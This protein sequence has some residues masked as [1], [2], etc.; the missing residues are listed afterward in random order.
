MLQTSST[1]ELVIVSINCDVHRTATMSSSTACIN[2]LTLLRL[3]PALRLATSCLSRPFSVLNRPPPKYEGHVPLNALERSALAAG[4]AVMSLFNPRR[5]GTLVL[6]ITSTRT[7]KPCLT[8]SHR[9]HRRAR[10]NHLNAILHL[11]SS[12]RHAVLSYRPAHPPRPPTHNLPNHFP[13]PPTHAP[14]RQRRPRLC[15][16]ARP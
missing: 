13:R 6:S 14:L 11:P 1:S 10:R 9:P 2:T 4:S 7:N 16:L 3:P 15:L 5:G 12:R 8:T